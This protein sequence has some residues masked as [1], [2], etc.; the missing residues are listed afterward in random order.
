MKIKTNKQPQGSALLVAILPAFIVG[1]ALA[2]SLTLVSVQNQSTLRSQSWNSA[3]P[4]M[5]AGVEEALTALQYYGT[6]NLASGGWTLN[7]SDGFYHTTSTLRN[8]TS[9]NGYSYDVGI[10]RP[11][12]GQPDQPIIESLGYA[13]A[14]LNLATSFRGSYGMILG[15]MIPLYTPDIASTKRKVRVVAKNDPIFNRA[16]AAQGVI[17]LNGRFVLTDSFDSSDPA[18]NTLG[19]YDSSKNK[20]NGDVAT[21]GKLINVNNAG[22]MGKASTGPGGSIE[23]GT[24]ASVGDKAW[25]SAGTIGIQPGHVTDDMNVDFPPVIVPAAAIAGST[26]Y[27]GSAGGAKLLTGSVL[28]SPTYFNLSS[29]SG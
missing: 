3:V 4:V 28:G 26:S 7:S 1:M 21:N 13:P 18:Y 5:E 22:I 2:S 29:L 15:G 23:L 9:Q 10:K 25:V 17:N 24:W 27:S 16:M 12:L 6:T 14:S 19:K 8:G 20:A 11:A